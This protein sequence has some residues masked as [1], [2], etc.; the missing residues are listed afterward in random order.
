MDRPKRA[1]T[2]VTDFRRYHLSGDLDKELEG[3]VDNRVSLFEMSSVEELKRQLEEERENSRKLQEDVEMM[4]IRNELEVEKLK[5]QQWQTAL[6]KLKEA[7]EQA[8]QEHEVCMNKMD[9]LLSQHKDTTSDSLNWLKAQMGKMA[10]RQEPPEDLE[11]KSK[12]QEEAE[13]AREAAILALKKQQTEINNKLNELQTVKYKNKL[14]GGSGG[15]GQESTG[16][17][18]HSH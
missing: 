13:V 16:S 3:L 7:R 17:G 8:A 18:P 11:Q 1:A 14:R 12:E 4:R 10:Q 9:D 15:H 6:D 5:Q 2:K